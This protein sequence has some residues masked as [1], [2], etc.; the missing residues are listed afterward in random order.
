MCAPEAFAIATIRSPIGP[1]P[2][3]TTRSPELSSDRS[4]A[5]TAQASGS[6]SAPARSD[7]SSGMRQAI[8]AGSTSVRAQAP[9]RIETRFGHIDGRPIRQSSH[10]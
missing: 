9:L 3:P 8:C 6:V 7:T 2:T 1:P 10:W 5:R 4:T